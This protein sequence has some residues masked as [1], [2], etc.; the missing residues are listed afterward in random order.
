M[1]LCWPGQAE[2][3]VAALLVRS[4]D[5]S[6]LKLTQEGV[7]IINSHCQQDIYHNKVNMSSKPVVRVPQVDKSTTATHHT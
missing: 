3:R 6:T 2:K 5:V 4:A 1:Q 7:E